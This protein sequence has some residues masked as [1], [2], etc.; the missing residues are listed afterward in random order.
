MY[1]WRKHR[2]Y[3]KI[4]NTDNS[5]TYIIIVDGESVEVNEDVFKVYAHGCHK[6]EYMERD[7][8]RYREMQDENGMPVLD[9]NG[10][11]II[12]PEREVS[13][14][15]LIDEEWEFASSVQSPE[16]IVMERVQK[17]ELHRCLALLDTGERALIEAL[18]FD[19]M[20]ER[21]YSMQSG[22]AQKT[23]NDRKHR[24]LETLKRFLQKNEK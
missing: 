8:K 22:I 20:T 6:M 23:I 15:Q 18:F 3:R 12:L 17:D 7:L 10:Q 13:L 9:D 5:H 14:E 11:P 2:N 4:E 24:V 19:G 21:A 1:N 16:E